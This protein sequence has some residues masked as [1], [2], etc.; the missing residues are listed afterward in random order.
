MN[1]SQLWFKIHVIEKFIGYSVFGIIVLTLVSC[2][3]YLK[4]LEWKD[5]RKRKKNKNK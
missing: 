3:G 1:Y 5:N 2:W 4:Y